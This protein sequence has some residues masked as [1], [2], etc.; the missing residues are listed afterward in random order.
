MFIVVNNKFHIYE[1]SK[2][3]CLHIKKKSDGQL[4]SGNQTTKTLLLPFIFI[5]S[6][7]ISI[8]IKSTMRPSIIRLLA[9]KVTFFTRPQCGLCENAKGALSKAWDQSKTK[10]DYKEVDI[11]KPENSEWFDKYVSEITLKR[12]QSKDLY[13]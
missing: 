7:E 5:V 10:F 13:I 2:L 6:F 12:S 8:F 4:L 1:L 3:F 11:T 9:T